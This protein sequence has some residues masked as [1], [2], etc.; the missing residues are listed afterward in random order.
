MLTILGVKGATL[1][2]AG[3]GI[4]F[5]IGKFEVGKLSKTHSHLFQNPTVFY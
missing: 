3:E 4:S 2:G 1:E 5:Y